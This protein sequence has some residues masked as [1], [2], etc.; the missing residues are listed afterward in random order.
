MRHGEG[1]WFC[2]LFVVRSGQTVEEK[3][4][5]CCFGGV[6]A[7]VHVNSSF[8]GQLR[9]GLTMIVPQKTWSLKSLDPEQ[10]DF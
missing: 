6:A 2:H 9:L 8:R 4:F 1:L 3:K 5:E 7:S 10:T